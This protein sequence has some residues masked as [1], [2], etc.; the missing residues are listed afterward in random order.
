[1]SAK[2][3]DSI[4]GAIIVFFSIMM[5]VDWKASEVT[6]FDLYGR[7]LFFGR[8]EHRCRRQLVG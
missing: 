8:S 4:P 2:S 1:M 7:L 5:T 3:K 6:R